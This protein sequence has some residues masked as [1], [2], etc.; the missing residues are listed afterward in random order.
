M[1]S[2]YVKWIVNKISFIMDNGIMV[3]ILDVIMKWTTKSTSIGIRSKMGLDTTYSTFTNV[4]NSTSV[5]ELSEGLKEFCADLVSQVTV[6]INASLDAKIDK[7]NEG[8]LTSPLMLTGNINA[9]P[10]KYRASIQQI[11]VTR[12]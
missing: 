9:S 6:A 5:L 8:L 12:D 2:K 4:S 3:C 10:M 1:S 11:D 7:L